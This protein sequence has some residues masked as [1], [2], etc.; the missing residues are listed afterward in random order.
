MELLVGRTLLD[1]WDACKER[2]L[3]LQLDHAAWIAA[4][5]ADGLHCAHEL[6]DEHG[7]R[8]ASSTATST[9]ATSS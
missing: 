9:R 1:V 3:S 4:R 7:P 8:C 5:V 2:K 6:T